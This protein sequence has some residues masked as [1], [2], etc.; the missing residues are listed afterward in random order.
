[1]VTAQG[2]GTASPSPGNADQVANVTYDP[3]GTFGSSTSTCKA[4]T[5]VVV[6]IYDIGQALVNYNANGTFAPPTFSST[7][8]AIIWFEN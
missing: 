1:M 8:S 7:G 3:S 6:T 5:Q 4:G 2:G